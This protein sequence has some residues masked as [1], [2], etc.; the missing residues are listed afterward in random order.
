MGKNFVFWMTAGCCVLL[1]TAGSSWAASGEESPTSTL[2]VPAQENPSPSFTRKNWSLST[3]FVSR[4]E[5]KDDGF[6]SLLAANAELEFAFSPW[7]KVEAAPYLAYYSS[8]VQERFSD[9]TY[10]SRL[11]LT[12]GHLTFTPLKGLSIKAGAIPQKDLNNS[13]LISSFRSF[14]GG[15]VEYRG[16]LDDE[17]G[18]GLRARYLIPTSSSLNTQRE[19]EEKLPLF[20]TQ[21]FFAE[22]SSADWNWSLQ[23][24]LFQWSSLPSKVAY[25]STRAGNTP[26]NQFLDPEA[27]FLYGY[28]G[29]FGNLEAMYFFHQG[30]RLGFDFKRFSNTKAPSNLADSQLISLKGGHEF[31]D[32]GVA[33][34]AGSFFSEADATV[35]KYSSS[36]FGNTNREGNFLE[37]KLDFKKYKFYLTSKYVKANELNDGPAQ[38]D[39]DSLSFMV[40][41][42]EFQF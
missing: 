5:G 40:E 39:A 10:D 2:A 25:E 20:Q 38:D 33:V 34:E 27:K 3:G 30:S 17:T 8:R 29:W 37:A 21:S 7:M 18:F 1:S 9:D 12:Y 11:G 42:Y 32:F 22:T 28:K 4:N 19:D 23:G 15:A 13:L 24:G 26:A 6:G 36:G 14:P 31:G 35:A 41:S 16:Q